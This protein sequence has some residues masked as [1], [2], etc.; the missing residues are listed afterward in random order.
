M[1]IKFGC[2][3]Y[4]QMVMSDVE[5]RNSKNSLEEKISLQLQ[6]VTKN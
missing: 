3:V 2:I 4:N 5:S 1:D 6:F